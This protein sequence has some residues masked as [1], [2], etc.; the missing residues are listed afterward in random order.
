MEFGKQTQKRKHKKKELQILAPDHS[1][2]DAMYIVIVIVIEVDRSNWSRR[3]DA[4]T[5]NSCIVL[6]IRPGVNSV[7]WGG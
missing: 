3:R 2:H 6:S 1:G 7:V 4:V 5:L